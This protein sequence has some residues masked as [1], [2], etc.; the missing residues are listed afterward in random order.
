MN[1]GA[2]SS[3][4]EADGIF[5]DNFLAFLSKDGKIGPLKALELSQRASSCFVRGRAICTRME[6]GSRK[7]GPK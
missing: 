3:E 5:L 6:I 2:F 1:L 7:T 4:G